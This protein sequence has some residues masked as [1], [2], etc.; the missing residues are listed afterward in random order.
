[1]SI[2][3]ERKVVDISPTP[4]MLEAYSAWLYFERLCLNASFLPLDEHGRPM[5]AV[6]TDND[7]AN[8]HDRAI[9]AHGN[10]NDFEAH[11]QAGLEAQRRATLVLGAVGCGWTGRQAFVSSR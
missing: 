6:P 5:M 9:L 7:G 4:V 2:R 1:M 3:R 10:L 11:R 8:F